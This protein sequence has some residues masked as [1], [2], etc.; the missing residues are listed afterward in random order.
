VASFAE[1][2]RTVSSALIAS[3]S[4]VAVALI[5]TP[6]VRKWAVRLGAVDVPGGRRIHA[7]TI[8]RLGGVAVIVACY[9]AVMLTMMTGIFPWYEHTGKAIG[10][11][12]LGGLLIAGVG[13]ID[14][15]RSLGAK[16]KLFAQVLAASLAWFGGASINSFTF[17]AFS[18]AFPPL[19]SY[20]ISVF[21]ICAFINAMNL[22]DG[23]DGLA[24]GLALF[25]TIT[26]SVI[27]FLTDNSVALLL[28]AAL[29][30][31]VLGFL[32]YNFNPATIFLGDTGSMFLGYVLGGAALLTGRQ[33]ESTV[34]SLLVPILALGLPLT[35][36][37][38]TMVRRFLSRRPI[39]SPD[40]GHIHHRLLDVGLTHR[41]AVLMLYGTTLLLCLTAVAVAFGHDWQ[42][43]AALVGALLTLI[44]VA[45]VAGY[46]EFAKRSRARRAAVLSAPTQALR[47]SL[48][49]LLLEMERAKTASAA[50]ASLEQVLR[51]G[52]FAYAEYLP[53]GD[54][55]PLWRWQ[56]ETP[57]ERNKVVITEFSIR[58]LSGAPESTL[59][60]A[61]L[62]ET[63]KLPPQVEVLLQLV[64]DA[65]ESGLRRVGKQRPSGP[66]QPATSTS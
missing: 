15:T 26:N 27:A 52:P 13:I 59:R 18:F 54:S 16:R 56:S 53:P 17:G 38:F 19:L 40:R 8:P 49:R 47:R 21:W 58:A 60:F 66:L 29:G 28:N 64:V 25:A 48:P 31:A 55:I 37:L 3:S 24:G 1:P 65:M 61:C 35:D 20:L 57:R 23:L 11:L 6:F 46:F 33:K 50:W 41:R 45:Q 7:E 14:D 43:G 36:T 4:A 22:I 10:L 44:G 2:L 30:G 5:L 63:K 51:E 39:F 9:V 32:F 34:A 42:V 12:A 62:L